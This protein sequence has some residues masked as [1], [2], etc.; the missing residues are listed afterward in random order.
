MS[1]RA[2]TP[3]S[4]RAP[5]RAA[6]PASRRVAGPAAALPFETTIEIRDRCLCLFVQRAARMLA[7][8][9]DAALRPVRLTHGQFSLLNALN[10]PHPP[11][12]GEV[13]A[14]LGMDRT[15]LTALLKTL[16][17]RGLVEVRADE[18]D[19]RSRRLMLAPAGRALLAAAYPLWRSAHRALEATLVA[20]TPERLRRELAQL[21]RRDG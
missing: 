9:F 13:A 17:R 1:R 4:S 3:G 20:S 6:R 11:V 14:L 8:R 12:M 10:R 2:A 18:E 16:Q 7:R 15:T 5:V 21:A 19:R